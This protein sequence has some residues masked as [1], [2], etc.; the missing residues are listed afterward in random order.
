MD[1]IGFFVQKVRIRVR[2]S[3]SFNNEIPCHSIRH[4]SMCH[5]TLIRR[6][7]KY[8]GKKVLEIVTK[9]DQDCSKKLIIMIE[10]VGGH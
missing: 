6:K 3:V 4:R 2:V 8:R 5:G 7:K 1:M 9:S 10:T